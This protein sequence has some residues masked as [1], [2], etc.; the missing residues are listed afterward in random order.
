MDFMQD[1]V[2]TVCYTALIFILGAL[3]GKPLWNWVRKLLPWES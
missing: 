3:V 2:G 1:V